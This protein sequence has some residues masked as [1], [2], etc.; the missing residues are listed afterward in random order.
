MF[1]QSQI[2]GAAALLLLA[3][4]AL[5]SAEVVLNRGNDTDPATLDHHLVSTV[6]ESNILRDLYEGL[7][8]EAADGAV[9]P[10]VAESWE[11]SDDGKTYTFHLRPDALWS[12]GDRVTSEDFA[13]ALNRIMDPATA[14]PYASLLF[15]ILNAE[16]VA[17]GEKPGSA[18]GVAAPDPSTL[19]ITLRSSSPYFLQLLTHQ[20]AKPLHRKS[21]ETFGAD[22]SKPGNLVSN[23]AYT[24]E[25]F[26]PNDRIVLKKNP[27]FWDA[28]NVKIDTINWIPFEDRSA[29]VRR[30]EA[31]E[32]LICSDLPAEQLGYLKEKHAASLRIA[33]YLGVYSLPV[34]LSKEKLSDPRVRHAISMVIDREFLADE[35]WQGS[36]LPAYALVPPGIANFVSTPP[37][38]P[39][40]GDDPIDREDA[41]KALLKEAGVTDLTVSLSYNSSEDHKNTMAAVGDML[42]NIGIATTM[43]EMEGTTYFKYLREGGDYDI[44]RAGWIGDFDDPQT[45]LF[46]Y[47]TGVPFN[48]P[49]WSN[50]AYDAKMDEAA[51]T[52]DLRARA[53]LLAEAEAIFLE[54]LP[55]I[56]ILHYSSRA[57]VSDKLTGW[58]D[59]ILDSHATRW[60]AFKE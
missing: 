56:P 44:A 49:G 16:D 12:N 26:T 35:V 32:V 39:Y 55:S 10:S 58:E 23:G 21:F 41:A 9:I 25:S 52:T 28:A 42:S 8:T 2:T 29:C 22:F 50:P 36:M 33:P 60:L 57:L 38:L 3:S 34:K 6:S 43:N 59:N 53:K 46:L 14:A 1:R 15:D 54:D 47:Q 19:V 37:Q 20:T 30:F 18:L 7:V 11:I 17:A 31:G 45:F 13:F 40:A 51:V 4:T 48:Y 27:L 5:A 24:L